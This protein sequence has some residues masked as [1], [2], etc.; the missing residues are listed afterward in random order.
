MRGTGSWRV[1][2]AWRL[3]D[4]GRRI[5]RGPQDAVKRLLPRKPGAGATP[6]IT[7]K[8]QPMSRPE[9]GRAALPTSVFHE[10]CGDVEPNPRRPTVPMEPAAR[11]YLCACCR[12]PV[13][14]CSDCVGLASRTASAFTERRFGGNRMQ[15]TAPD[16]QVARPSRTRSC[17]KVAFI[18]S[19][20]ILGAC[21]P[22]ISLW[23]SRLSRWATT[24]V[25]DGRSSSTQELL[26]GLP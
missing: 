17:R 16:W 12:T 21:R 4:D 2:K 20:I 18:P 25:R 15:P 22:S 9:P 5:G 3:P 23:R 11:H 13:L 7:T 10:T 8:F 1:A 26:V 24:T 14:I 6:A 19:S